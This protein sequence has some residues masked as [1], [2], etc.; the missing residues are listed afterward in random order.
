MLLRTQGGRGASKLSQQAKVKGEKP[1]FPAPTLNV[2][3]FVIPGQRAP[4]N[5]LKSKRFD[6]QR[7]G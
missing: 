5:K 2:T 1:G 6:Q 3:T 7:G 4:S